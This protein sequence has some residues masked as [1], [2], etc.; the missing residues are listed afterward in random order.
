M[1]HIVL[2]QPEIPPNTG[3]IIRLCANTGSRLHLIQP[4]GFE[5]DD[6]RLRRAG[7]D[8]H[9]FAEVTQHVSL[10]AFV[11]AVQPSRL[12]GVSTRG[13]QRYDQVEYEDG[14]ALM[15]GPETRGLPQAVLDALP[16][17]QRLRLPMRSGQRSLNL[18]NSVAVLLYEAWRQQGFAGGE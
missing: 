16:A 11:Q 6:K 3:N 10:D 14:D 15:F 9:E 5:L 1:F 2:Y 8:Y 13:R 7:L 18:S 12:F 4:L 17:E